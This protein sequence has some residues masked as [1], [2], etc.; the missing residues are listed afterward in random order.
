MRFRKKVV[1]DFDGVLHK[2]TTRWV[3]P[4]EVSDGPVEGALEAVQSYLDAGFEVIVVSSRATQSDG[5][6]A[7]ENWL[8]E[9][10][11]PVLKVTHEKPGAV[12][13]IDDRGY[14]FTGSW[15]TAEFIRNFKPWN[16]QLGDIEPYIDKEYKE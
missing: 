2:F 14:H 7:I 11:F 16:R 5:K 15:P 6:L 8:F 1:V 3:R 9:H 13:Y 4:S 12:I 10:G